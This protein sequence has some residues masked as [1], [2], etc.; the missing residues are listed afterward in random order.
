MNLSSNLVRSEKK[1]KKAR[2]ESEQQLRTIREEI[3]ESLRKGLWKIRE[4]RKIES[5]WKVWL[6]YYF[7]FS[8]IFE[9]ANNLYFIWKARELEKMSWIGCRR[10]IENRKGQISVVVT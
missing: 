9:K 7:F 2:Y 4:A 8:H 10:K 1:F 5:F 6:L 3:Q